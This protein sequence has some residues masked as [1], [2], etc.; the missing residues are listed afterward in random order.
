MNTYVSWKIVIFLQ[1]L[2]DHKPMLFNEILIRYVVYFVYC[3]DQLY[4]INCFDDKNVEIYSPSRAT[5]IMSPV[6]GGKLKK[7]TIPLCGV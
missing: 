6:S 5:I 2:L 7:I 1:K 4:C 3:K